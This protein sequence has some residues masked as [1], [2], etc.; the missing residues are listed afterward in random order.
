MGESG[1]VKATLLHLLGG[2][3][4][5]DA[6]SIQFGDVDVTRL[7][8][9]DLARFRNRTIGF[10]WQNPSLLPEFTALENVSMP[11]LIRGTLPSE[12]ASTAREMLE[13]VGLADR[14]GH[15]GGELS[16]GEQQ[17]VALARALAARPQ[18][19]LADEP[20]GSLDSRT[21]EAMMELIGE[22][23]RTYRLTSV[24]VTHN[25]KFA[26]KCDRVLELKKGQ[27]QNYG[28]DVVAQEVEVVQGATRL[29]GG[30]YV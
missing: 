21:G 3:D 4:K 5:P 6:G 10:V 15:R 26:Q 22:L 9:D 27:L 13:D 30:T 12:A 18:V 29:D 2:L 8:V 19:L 11:L 28:N 24:L 23:C 17:R 1:C 14:A 25:W 20:T 7:G 16:G